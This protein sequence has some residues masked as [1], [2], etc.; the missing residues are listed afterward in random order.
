[1]LHKE[2]LV[3][4]RAEWDLR[5]WL[6]GSDY[7]RMYKKG[8]GCD[9]YE[10]IDK[11]H[12]GPFLFVC[13][14]GNNDDLYFHYCSEG[15]GLSFWGGCKSQRYQMHNSYLRGD[16]YIYVMLKFFYCYLVDLEFI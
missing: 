11:Q 3:K 15:G 8:L 1:M 2:R 14:G 12:L 9:W 5:D 10:A 13:D 16:K 6:A 7:K 4:R